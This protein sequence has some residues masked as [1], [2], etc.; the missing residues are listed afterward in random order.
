MSL[1]EYDRV[2]AAALRAVKKISLSGREDGPFP[3]WFAGFEL[4]DRS[5]RGLP[6]Q[7]IIH[8]INFT[9]AEGDL[10]RIFGDDVTHW[11]GFEILADDSPPPAEPEDN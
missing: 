9:D 3:D 10:S 11:E 6:P 8:V 2:S 5:A 7:I 4:V 1:E